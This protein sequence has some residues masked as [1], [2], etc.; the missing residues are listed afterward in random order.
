MRTYE[1]QVF[2]H[3]CWSIKTVADLCDQGQSSSRC[4]QDN[5]APSGKCR[6]QQDGGQHFKT[7]QKTTKPVM[8]GVRPMPGAQAAERA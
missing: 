4:G 1:I 8:S 5:I 2:K 6:E 3:P 7:G